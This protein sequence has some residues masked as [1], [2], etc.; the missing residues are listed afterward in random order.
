[1]QSTFIEVA[2]LVLAGICAGNAA[3]LAIKEYSLGAIKD[4]LAGAIG[5]AAGYFLLAFIPPTVDAGANPVPDTSLA[6]HMVTLALV[7]VA[8]G[9][10]LTLVLG[11]VMGGVARS[12]SGL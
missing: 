7:G 1:M 6:N 8:A 5:G 3:G 2:I 9:G 10:V 4:T 11:F 12:R